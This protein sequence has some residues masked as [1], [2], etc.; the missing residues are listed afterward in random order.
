MVRKKK[1]R[2]TLVPSGMD[3]RHRKMLKVS[4]LVAVISLV[5]GI[6]GVI[7]HNVLGALSETEEEHIFF[8]IGIVGLMVFFI[9]I[10]GGM[11]IFI[12]GRRKTT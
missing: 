4:T 11:V 10:I 9:A 8:L 2:L 12:K 1:I 5:L 6:V 3:E 7:L